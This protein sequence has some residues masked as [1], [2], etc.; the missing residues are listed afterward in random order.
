MLA[1]ALWSANYV[2]LCC[3]L[4]ALIRL[5]LGCGSKGQ[6]QILVITEALRKG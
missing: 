2:C 6:R 1:Q 5:G 4:L 3:L